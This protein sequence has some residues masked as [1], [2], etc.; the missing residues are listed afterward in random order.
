MNEKHYC[1][2]CARQITNNK[3]NND[4]ECQGPVKYMGPTLGFICAECSKDL[5]EDGLFPEE[6]NGLL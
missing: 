3:N 6:R 4:Y 2:V 1:C 5:D